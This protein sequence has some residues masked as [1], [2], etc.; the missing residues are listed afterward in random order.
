M[1]KFKILPYLLPLVFA[2][3]AAG[4]ATQ[5]SKPA[6]GAAASEIKSSQLFNDDW[7]FVRDLDTSNFMARLPEF[8]SGETS[9]EDVSLPHTAR[10]EP[11]HKT[12][13]QWQGTALYRKIFRL[14]DSDKGRHI[15]L[16]FEGAMQVADIYLNGKHLQRHLGGYLP[17]YV[18]ISSHVRFGEENILLVRVN[19]EDNAKF[20]PG[21]PLADLDF[22]YYSGLYRNVYL[23]TKDKLHISDAVAANRVAGGGVLLHYENVSASQATLHVQ[24]EVKNDHED[25][26]SV[27]VRLLLSDI[28][29][30]MVGEA[31]ADAAAVTAGGFGTFRQQISIK[32]PQLWSP[33]NPYLY[34]LTVELL[35]DGK[36]LE[37]TQL[38]TGAR[39][40]RFAKD[41]FY[42]NGEKLYL[43]GTNR[44][45]EYPYLGYA[46]SDNANYR[47]AYKIKE[48]GFNFVRLSHY[49]HSPSFMRACDELGLLVMDA[50]PGWQFFGD[51]EF[52]DNA[53][54]DVRDMVRRDRNHPSVVLWEASLNESEMTREFMQRAH[55]AVHEELP[56]GEVYTCGWLDEVYDVFIPA[57][58]HGKAPDYWNKYAKDKPIFIAE[59]GDWEYYAQ[60]AGFNQKEFKNLKEEERTSRQLRGMGQKR[61][62]QQAL[63]YQEAHNS[64]LQGPAAGD[65]NWLM[66]DYKRGYADDIESSGI[67][68]IV[69]LPKFAYYFYQS[70]AGPDL[71]KDAV[72]HKPMVFIANYW[73][74]PSLKTVRVFSNCDEVEL[75][76]N[77]KTIARQQPDQNANSTHLPHPSFT[78]N[79]P[80]YEAGKLTAIGYIGGKK[81][82]EHT[83][84]TAGKAAK[85]QLHADYSGKPLQAGVNDV[86][87]VYASITDAKGA[88]VPD[89]TNQVSFTLEGDA[90]IVGD[91]TVSAEAG[92]AA[93]LVKAGKQAGSI[94]VQAQ[95]QGLE[96]GSYTLEVELGR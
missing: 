43:R 67:M 5:S 47:D 19:N 74:D 39:T 35:Q 81:A 26:R 40:F 56:V 20:P 70:Q 71:T 37:Q 28:D 44:H 21:K 36:V 75:Q 24:T 72:F 32:N 6:T 83:Q 33:D 94:K 41:G 18:D 90:Q 17:F 76:L 11:I 34:T 23:V 2:W 96:A 7:K 10:I 93:I 46:L 29:G 64:N 88:V 58:Q 38:K 77:G 59:Y 57:R 89:A 27:Q 95:S 86:V 82:A 60:N 87:F 15:A 73:N 92:I 66:F 85:L 8:A 25:N 52:Q 78:F 1:L 50:I 79:V 12:E 91:S 63:N 51:K 31:M 45:Q 68:D 30:N 9:W 16:H 65:A 14:P 55:D 3:L 13:Q 22:N 54:Q 62:L 69:R 53:I 42:L 84:Q 4:C 80:K 48:A 49:P 61:L